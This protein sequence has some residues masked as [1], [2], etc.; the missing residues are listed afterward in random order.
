M[1]TLV[2][3]LDNVFTITPPSRDD[4]PSADERK[5]V[6]ISLQAFVFNVFGCIDNLAWVWV[7]EKGVMREDGKALARSA[8]GFRRS[9]KEVRASL[10]QELQRYFNGMEKWFRN[11]D[12]FRHA[13]AHRI[14][15]YIPPHVVREKNVDQ[16]REL[17]TAKI[18]ALNSGDTEEYEKLDAQQNHLGEFRPLMA[19]SFNEGSPTIVFHA[20]MLADFNTVDDIA[21]RIFATL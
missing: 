2:R 17:E 11:L 21:K 5:D 18:R 12:E 8:V 16:Y 19:H 3:C 6:E 10:P 9:C 20:Q 13:L 1:Y 7:S 4:V 15:F 14:P